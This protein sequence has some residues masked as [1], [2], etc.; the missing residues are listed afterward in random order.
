M[1]TER[2]LWQTAGVLILAIIAVAWG[3][4]NLYYKGKIK[5]MSELK[6][7]LLTTE[8]EIELLRPI[9]ILQKGKLP[10]HELIEKQ[11]AQ[12]S[13]KIP[14]EL[15]VPYL[16]QGFIVNSAKGLNITYDLITPM[17][18][19]QEQKYKRVPIKVNFSCDF[20]SLNS[21]IMNLENLPI[22]VRID[23]LDVSKASAPPLL[24]VKMDL[25]AFV[26]PGGSVQ[27]AS[28]KLSRFKV[29]LTDPFFSGGIKAAV[30]PPN[31][32]TKKQIKRSSSLPVFS[33]IF[34]GTVPKAFIGA[35]IAG[36]GESVDGYEV[37]EIASNK[38]VIVKKSGKI[39]TLTLGR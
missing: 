4:Y 39:Y 23:A 21:Y 8:K 17:A 22:T 34:E 10:V 30:P 6:M 31:K 25:S 5:Q 3:S 29:P 11:L 36:V 9:D 18:P 33:G 37:L 27:S 26:S 20:E 7:A 19:V 16:L 32:T 15:E 13:K 35:G 14:N 2:P 38:K 28:D 1:G 24:N 12:I